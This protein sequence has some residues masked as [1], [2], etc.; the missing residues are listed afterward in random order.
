M[1]PKKWPRAA[2]DFFLFFV[3]FGVVKRYLLVSSFASVP[4]SGED[5]LVYIRDIYATF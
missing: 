2:V 3:F 1:Q 5:E 4:D